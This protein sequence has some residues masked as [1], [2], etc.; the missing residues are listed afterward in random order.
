MYYFLLGQPFYVP[1]KVKKNGNPDD[2]VKCQE[3]TVIY[4]I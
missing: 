1:M 3:S 2:Y 4:N